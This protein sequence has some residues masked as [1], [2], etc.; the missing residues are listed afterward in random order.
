VHPRRVQIPIAHPPRV[1][2]VVHPAAPSAPTT[3]IPPPTVQTFSTSLHAPKPV[4]P[5][6]HKLHPLSRLQQRRNFRAN[7]R[8]AKLQLL[9][10]NKFFQPV[11]NHICNDLG[12]RK[13]STLSWKARMVRHGPTVSAMNTDALHR[14]AL[15]ATSLEPTQ[16]ILFINM[17]CLPTK[18][19]PTEILSVTSAPSKLNRSKSVSRLAATNCRMMMTPDLL[20]R[21]SWSPNLSSTAPSPMLTKAPAF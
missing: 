6:V 14:V 1:P 11:M 17:R 20:R 18:R 9:Q 15:R 8:E 4:P 3:S 16:S 19:S 21:L 2:P 7:Q 13:Q 10:A 5:R 12:K